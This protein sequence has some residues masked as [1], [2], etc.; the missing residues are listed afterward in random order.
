MEFWKSGKIRIHNKS[1]PK[2]VK[3]RYAEIGMD[4]DFFWEVEVGLLTVN[5]HFVICASH[6]YSTLFASITLVYD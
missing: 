1:K 2:L 5:L 3:E 6:D 4:F